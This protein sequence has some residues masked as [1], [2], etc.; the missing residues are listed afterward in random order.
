MKYFAWDAANNEK[1]KRERGISFEEIV[2]HIERGDVLD[3]LQHPNRERYGTQRIFVVDVEGYAYLIPFVEG[4]EEVT[5]KTIIPSR[6]ATRMY[7]RKESKQRKL[8]SKEEEIL[9]S[10]ER[11]GW[12]SVPRVKS[13]Q[14]RYRRYAE[15]TVRK[16]RRVNIRI[17]SKDLLAIQKRAVEE[18]LPYQ[19]LISSLL[20]KYVSGRLRE[21]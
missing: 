21:A 8:E 1:L 20:H 2:F 10:V 14:R 4:F 18:G 7:L 11:G 5:L 6:K 16:D 9:D 17:S 15:A 3:I 13:E 19:T 12:Q